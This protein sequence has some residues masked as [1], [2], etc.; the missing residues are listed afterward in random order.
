M[1]FFW[2]FARKKWEFKYPNSLYS[3]YTFPFNRMSRKVNPPLSYQ[4]LK[5]IFHNQNNERRR[6]N[7]S[8]DEVLLLLLG[9]DCLPFLACWRTPVQ[10]K[11][12]GSRDTAT[13]PRTISADKHLTFVH[14]HTHLTTFCTH[15]FRRSFIV[16]FV[17]LE[18]D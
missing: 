18:S 13:S 11:M 2:S 7:L 10:L 9:S 8:D 14:V 1:S 16:R 4:H 15:S 6:R 5:V 3:R 17:G 12:A